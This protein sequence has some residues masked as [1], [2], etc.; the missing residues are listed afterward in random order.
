[1][2][3]LR[4]PIDCAVDA[5]ATLTMTTPWLCESSRSSS[6]SADERRAGMDL[7]L[8]ARRVGSGLQPDRDSHFVALA[9]QTDLR[10]AAE[11][12]GGEAIIEGI[13][14]IDDRAVDTDD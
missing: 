6:A 9:K 11:R 5:S 2:S 1:M 3:P 14:V 10:G 8:L 7:D 12:L 13:R 4:K